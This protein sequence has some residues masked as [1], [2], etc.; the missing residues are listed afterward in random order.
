MSFHQIQ[1]IHHQLKILYSMK[2]TILV[3]LPCYYVKWHI[4][5]SHTAQYCSKTSLHIHLIWQKMP[6]YIILSPL[7]LREKT[8]FAPYKLSYLIGKTWHTIVFPFLNSEKIHLA[9]VL[10]TWWEETQWWS[11]CFKISRRFWYKILF[12][13]CT[14]RRRISNEYIH[15]CVGIFSISAI[16]FEKTF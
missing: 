10:N 8:Q 16:L 4:W 11:E 5:W 1:I 2:I 15:L 6:F 7:S 13:L 12:V 9:S 14:P 3:I